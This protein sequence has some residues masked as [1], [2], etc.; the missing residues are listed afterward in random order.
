MGFKR[1]LHYL[2]KKFAWVEVKFEVIFIKFGS[3]VAKR[4]STWNYLIHNYKNIF[5]NLTFV[6]DFC[7][8]KNRF[9]K[10]SAPDIQKVFKKHQN[11]TKN[12]FRPYLQC[13]IF[14]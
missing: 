6:L 14:C 7:I 9:V 2:G 11:M 8:D 10:D 13:F 5:L 1:T 4:L 12:A 3:L